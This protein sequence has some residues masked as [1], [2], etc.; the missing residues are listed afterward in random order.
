MSRVAIPNEQLAAHAARLAAAPSVGRAEL[1]LAFDRS[2]A[3]SVELHVEGRNFYPP[4]L[5]DI[6]AATS[7]VHI[8]QFGFRP[9][10]VGDRFA[11][12]LVA[13]AGEGVPVR[14]IVDRQ[15]SDPERGSRELYERLT[16]AGIQVCVDRATQPRAPRGPLGAGGAMRLEP[17]RAG[18]YRPPQGRRRRRSDRLGRR[19]R[20]RGSLRERRVPRP[21]RPRRGPRRR[22][23]AARVRRQP[24]LARRRDPRR[25]ASPALFPPLD[26]GASP[27]PGGRA[28]QRTGP[29]P[30]DHGRDRGAD[31]RST[32]H[33][34]RREPLRHRPRHDRA[35][36][37]GG[38]A[39]RARAPVRARRT[40]TTGPAVR[41]SSSTTS[42]CST[43][44]CSSSA[45]R[46]CCTRRRSSPTAS[47]CSSAPATSRR[48]A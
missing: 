24:A 1:A 20:D 11:D 3:S 16:A 12:A 27:V 5:A 40:R 43:P 46:R 29:V 26:E 15:G 10:L 41:P 6:A 48:G 30:A 42:G 47:T 8:N 37:A 14:L 36:R 4:L 25:R 28:P 44:A 13:K 45:T 39:R 34:R 35:D 9:G 21:V 38:A 19:S 22:A 7:S 32:G 23:A 2:S 17:A 31:R 33:A 18:A